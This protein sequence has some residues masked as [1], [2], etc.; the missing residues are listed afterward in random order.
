MHR[1]PTQMKPRRGNKDGHPTPTHSRSRSPEEE[2]EF[3]SSLPSLTPAQEARVRST[4]RNQLPATATSS[5]RTP[6][7]VACSTNP[8]ERTFRRVSAS[9][10]STPSDSMQSDDGNLYD[11][12][13]TE[14]EKE[15]GWQENRGRNMGLLVPPWS[16]P[17]LGAEMRDIERG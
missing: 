15:Q 17:S 5:V 6:E 3:L 11:P 9:L 10:L 14:E 1:R 7:R 12:N 8:T 4:P 16:G 13:K 2:R